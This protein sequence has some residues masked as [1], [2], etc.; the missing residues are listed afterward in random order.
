MGKQG[1]VSL[2]AAVAALWQS[3]AKA[4]PMCESF[5]V[6]TFLFGFV[7]A[8]RCRNLLFDYG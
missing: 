2:L 4:L 7:Y 8:V 3:L 5:R 1:R 6:L